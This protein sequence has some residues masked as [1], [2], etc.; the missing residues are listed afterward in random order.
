[1][2]KR[3][4]AIAAIL[5]GV[6]VPAFGQAPFV[7]TGATVSISASS[8]SARA[9]L[10]TT[11]PTTWICNTGTA[12]AY[13]GFGDSSVTATSSDTP[14]P[15]G[16]C[17]NF[18][19]GGRTYV[20]AITD[21][22]TTT[23]KATPGSGLLL[24]ARSGGGGL[25][26]AS[27]TITGGTNTRVLFDDSGV[28]GESAGLTYVKATGALT[29][30]KMGVG[31]APG[32][33]V[34]LIHGEADGNAYWSGHIAFPTGVSLQILNDASNAYVPFEFRASDLIFVAANG[35]TFAA[36]WSKV[37]GVA[38]ASLPAAATAGAGA[39]AYVTD[40]NATTYNS[41]VAGGGSN[42]VP[43]FSDGTNWRIG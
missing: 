6:A 20:A 21:S 42:G 9:E 16:A 32:G 29:A 43:V 39:R 23:I 41:I 14:L 19:P 10:V 17:G 13:I 12:L 34:F 26:V 7:A 30:T 28:V 3:L 2:F 4:L 25:A 35:V 18:S 15:G 40:A 38:V 22:S 5:F 33:A 36:P 27:T 11:A 37:Q 31:A 1:M 24:G 8:S